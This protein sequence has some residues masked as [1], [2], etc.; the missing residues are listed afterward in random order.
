MEIVADL[1][2]DG[3][4]F[5]DTRVLVVADDT[6]IQTVCR[7]LLER[8]GY[9][10][11]EAHDER[12]ALAGI[13][14]SLPDLVILNTR[15]HDRDGLELVRRLRANLPT[16]E[17]PII[18]VGD[19]VSENKDLEAGLEAGIDEYIAKPFGPQE[20]VLR[21]R[22]MTRL[23]RSQA[24]ARYSNEIR[25]ERARA[26]EVLLGL[27]HNLVTANNLET[28]IE[29]TLSAVAQLLGSRR[30]SIM[31]P[32]RTGRYLTV[33]GI[34]GMDGNVATGLCV[35]VGGVLAGAVFQTR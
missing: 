24:E 1:S 14:R 8:E 19:R 22:S 26:L 6:S 17:I 28:I 7:M 3:R 12:E 31:L 11:A 23:C 15:L 27:S 33:A 5:A 9:D 21:V 10:V 20:F 35:P 30:I 32:D 29:S 13:K 2:T 16:R 25:G 18:M 4:D 34:V